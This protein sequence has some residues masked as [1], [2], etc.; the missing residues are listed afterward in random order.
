LAQRFSCRS[1]AC[2][3]GCFNHCDRQLRESLGIIPWE[4]L[5]F[6]FV[7]EA[8]LFLT[9]ALAFE[10]LG[11]AASCLAEMAARRIFLPGGLQISGEL[12][13]ILDGTRFAEPVAL[14]FA[15]GDAF[16]KTRPI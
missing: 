15:K 6:G 1:W 4:M 5:I 16:W 9:G 14:R 7:K 12:A 13:G 10:R 8:L 11:P 3:S 2:L